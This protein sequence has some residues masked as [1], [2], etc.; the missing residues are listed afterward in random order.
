M[1]NSHSKIFQGGAFI[2]FIPSVNGLGEGGKAQIWEYKYIKGVT[3][4]EEGGGNCA[5]IGK[6]V[7]KEG[8]LVV[9]V[10]VVIKKENGQKKERKTQD[11][12][13]YSSDCAVLTMIPAPAALS[14][15][16]FFFT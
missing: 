6:A 3:E 4:R 10:V 14:F 7:E 9:V 5:G 13:G 16:L 8:G 1:K 11:F 15:L 12:V 2:D